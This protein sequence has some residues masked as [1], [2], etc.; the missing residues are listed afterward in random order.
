MKQ[1]IH[2]A[3]HHIA[4]DDLGMAEDRL[5][6]GLVEAVLVA[7]QADLHEGLD[8]EAELLAVEP[9]DIAA[10][11]AAGLELLGA[12]QARRGREADP[13]GKIDIGDPTLLLEYGRGS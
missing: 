12:A 11:G 8:A 13:L 2:L 6:E 9:G 3:G 7:L 1:I 5:A 10:D 4:A